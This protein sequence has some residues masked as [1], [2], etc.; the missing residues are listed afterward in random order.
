MLPDNTLLEQPGAMAMVEELR[1]EIVAQGTCNANVCFALDGSRRISS[2]NYRRVQD[3]VQ[4]VTAIVGVDTRAAFAAV[5]YGRRIR[6]ISRLTND[7]D[8]FLKDV[9]NSVS[10][11]ARR[12]FLVDG[13]SFCIHE[14][15][16]RTEDVNK[17][18]ILGDGRSPR[19]G[20]PVPLARR[21]RRPRGNMDICAVGVGF[22]NPRRLRRITGSSSRVLA[23]DG[24]FDLLDIIDQLVAEIC[25]LD[26]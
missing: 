6:P 25:G 20:N 17:I 10:L 19:G 23:I 4:L 3:F 13:L 22:G 14:L 8:S 18:V 21:N 12:S 24:Y 7:V 2:T 11:R 26:N 5:Q 15:W 16:P 9:D 1:E